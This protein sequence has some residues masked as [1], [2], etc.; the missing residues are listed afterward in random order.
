MGDDERVTDF[1]LDDSFLRHVSRKRDIKHGIVS[2]RAFQDNHPTLSFTLRDDDLKKDPGITQYQ[3]D[4]MLPFGDLPGIIFLSFGDLIESV[5]PPLPPWRAPNHDD[6]KYGHLHCCTEQPVD[7]E[8]REQL[9]KL[10][11]GNG[12]LRHF[13]RKPKRS[14]GRASQSNA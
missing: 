8:H 9:A 5:R 10:A 1:K 11:T 2:H 3:S 13:L 4:K 14:E 12:V 7:Q 6:A